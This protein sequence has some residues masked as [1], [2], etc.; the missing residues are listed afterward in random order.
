MLGVTFRL[1]MHELFLYVLGR[2]GDPVAREE[3]PLMKDRDM[4]GTVA[5]RL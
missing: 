4:P 3:P 1:K 2:I 5:A